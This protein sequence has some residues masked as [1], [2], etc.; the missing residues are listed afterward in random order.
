ML[1]TTKKEAGLTLIELMIGM[2][3]GLIVVGIATQMYISTLGLTKQT[4]ATT[5]LAQELRTVIDLIASDIKRAGYYSSAAVASNPYSSIVSGD[6]PIYVFDT[7]GDLDYDCVILGYENNSSGEHIYGYKLDGSNIS[8]LSVS[9][10]AAGSQA[11]CT[12]TSFI[13]SGGWEQLTDSR[14]VLINALSFTLEPNSLASWAAASSKYIDIEI[15][16]TSAVDQNVVKKLKESVR[17]RNEY[18]Y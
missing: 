6:L 17:V 12:G 18:T 1:A 2:L 3:L 4:A 11:D 8:M 10:Y 5:R 7:N 13:V 16:A 14:A 15:V 9:S